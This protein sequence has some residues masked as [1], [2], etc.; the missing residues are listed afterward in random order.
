MRHVEIDPRVE[1]SFRMVD[2]DGVEY[3]GEY[4]EI[5]PHRRLVFTLFMEN[6]PT[7]P[8]RVV[9][10]ITPLKK[11]CTLTVSHENLPPD[12]ARYTEA[13]WTGALYGLGVTL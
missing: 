5:T 11:G 10:E 4:S 6:R 3:I 7:V 8:T 13:R 12:C 2:H 1:G 9:M